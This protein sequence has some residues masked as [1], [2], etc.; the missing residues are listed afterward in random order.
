MAATCEAVSRFQRKAIVAWRRLHYRVFS[1]KAFRLGSGLSGICVSL[2]KFFK[3]SLVFTTQDEVGTTFKIEAEL[4]V[5]S[6]G[7]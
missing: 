6:N 5:G 2:R 3:K 7:L 4:N 1:R